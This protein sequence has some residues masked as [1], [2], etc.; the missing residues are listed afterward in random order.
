MPLPRVGIKEISTTI[1]AQSGDI[2]ILGGLIN[3]RKAKANK[4]VPFFSS[5][6]ILGY[7]FKYES[8]ADESRELVIMLRVTII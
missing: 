8:L 1:G 6:P 4:G 3:K 7:L 2:I 5:I